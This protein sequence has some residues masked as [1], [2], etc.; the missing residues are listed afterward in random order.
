MGPRLGYS[1][2]VSGFDMSDSA[3][4]S[5]TKL[6]NEVEQKRKED[7]YR[8]YSN[9]FITP[10]T[11]EHFLQQLAKLAGEDV[12]KRAVE[13]FKFNESTV[14]ELM[15]FCEREGGLDL[16]MFVLGYFGG[17]EVLELPRLNY[18]MDYAGLGHKF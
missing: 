18:S 16:S 12:A 2:E 9:S 6:L 5:W 8:R 15:N 4:D 1:W 14:G 3:S 11:A 10:G 7:E 13:I 17:G